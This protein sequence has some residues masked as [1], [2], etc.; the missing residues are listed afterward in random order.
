MAL[1]PAGKAILIGAL[2]VA[3][4]VVGIYSGVLDKPHRKP[5]EAAV[6]APMPQTESVAER[7]APTPEPAPV[8]QVPVEQPAVKKNDAFDALIRE[9][10]TK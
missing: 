9:S 10:G 3:A 7:P 1:K 5:P 2:A 8:V 6:V 4:A